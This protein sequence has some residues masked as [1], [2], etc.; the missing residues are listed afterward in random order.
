MT[1]S[2]NLSAWALSG[3]PLIHP[4]DNL[5][6]IILHAVKHAGLT[7][8][9]HDAL[10]VSSKIVSKSEGRYVNLAEIVPSQRAIAVAMETKKDPRVVELVLRESRLV[11]R[12]APNVLIVE[13]RL[14]FVSA[15]AGIDQS[16]IED[17]DDQ[18]LLL[19]VDPDRS[20]DELRTCIRE[21]TNK[22][23]AVIISDTHGRP[24]RRGNVGVAIGVSGM[25]AVQD[26]RGHYD[27]YG[28]ELRVTMQGFAD[29]VA[30]AAH[31]L[32]G[33]ADEGRP[34]VLMRGLNYP[35][36][37]GRASHLNRDPGQDLYR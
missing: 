14:G 34:V 15:N 28:R 33:E 4:G 37:E 2:A 11:S 30:S 7:L 32:C 12:Q 35:V 8:H 18:V 27:L 20:A 31:L 10:V 3:I 22:E 16:N 5:C 36:G 25:Q 6:D 24:F 21:R 17:G 19:P 13:H 23:V 9:D 1:A 29:L 26:L